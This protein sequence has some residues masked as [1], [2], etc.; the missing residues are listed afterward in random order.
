MLDSDLAHLYAVATSSLQEQVK[1][2]II[3][4]A[5]DVAF[6]SLLKG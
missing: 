2:T 6:G 1:R 3:R 5:D 4:F